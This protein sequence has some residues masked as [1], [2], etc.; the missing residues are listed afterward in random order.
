MNSA[1]DGKELLEA[2]LKQ[3]DYAKKYIFEAWRFELPQTHK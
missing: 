3:F 2:L 1:S